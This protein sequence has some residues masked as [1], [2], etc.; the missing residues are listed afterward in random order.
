MLQQF[1]PWFKV[2]SA[3]DD[4]RRRGRILIILSLAM[5]GV[6]SLTTIFALF[7]QPPIPALVTWALSFFLI[8]LI[9]M[10]ARRAYI[11]LA[12]MILLG[13]ILSGI[14]ITLPTAA[15]P[16]ASGYFLVFVVL[17]AGL[18][19]RP[20]QMWLILFVTLIAFA[21][22]TLLLARPVLATLIGQQTVGQVVTLL[23][24]VAG[25]SAL[26][27]YE[28]HRALGAAR[29]AQHSAEQTAQQLE[30]ANA[31]L[32]ERVQKRTA[33]LA[34]SL[35]IA[36]EREA[37]LTRLLSENTEQRATIQEMSVPV[38][39]VTATTL[40]MPL[41]GALDAERL[42]AVQTQSLRAL[43]RSRAQ[44]LVLDITGVPVID[45]QV[46]QGIL[47]VV[48]SSRLLGSTVVLVGVRP[49]VAQTI[50][51]LGIVLADVA[52]FSDLQSALHG[53]FF[54]PRPGRMGSV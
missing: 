11:T 35:R 52:I 33:A 10:L 40:V 53:E 24:G 2:A 4:L 3:D 16:L 26:G 50:V 39:P 14:V 38:I 5:L 19:L 6:V 1:S 47:S 13:G 32:E 34:E 42:A 41:I 29:A 36:E 44:T 28:M 20:S 17:T 7:T 9:V 12:S 46:A 45:S 37:H 21:G 15:P 30:Q 54:R 27:A 8:V 43:E 22:G 25:F 49:E 18:V 31:V 51:G 48:Q 23:I